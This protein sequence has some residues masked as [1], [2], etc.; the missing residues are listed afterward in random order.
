MILDYFGDDAQISNCQCDV[1]RRG[2][3][4]DVEAAADA[5]GVVIPDETITMIR[6]MLSAIARMNGRFGV[7]AVAEV[8]TG[9]ESERTRKWALNQLSV[10]GLLRAH[11]IKRV[12][13]MLHRLLESGLARQRDPE[14]TRFMPVIELTAAGVSVMKG[15]QRPPASLADLLPRTVA[16][17]RRALRPVKVDMEEDQSFDRAAI[18]RFERLRQVR[19][20][21][22]RDRQ[23]PPYVICHDSTLKSIAKA[24]P[25]SLAKLEQ[26]KG[27]GPY[28]V[29]QYGEQLIAALKEDV[30]PAEPRYVDDV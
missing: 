16:V 12:I 22:A 23:L 30:A 4:I 15:E 21:L 9:S 17:E 3:G 20:Q 27:M 19:T 14:G 7:G 18:A 24:A 26:I 11:T 10:Y 8:L 6:Q 2:A 29:K 25:D 1:C 28:K 5:V 13:A